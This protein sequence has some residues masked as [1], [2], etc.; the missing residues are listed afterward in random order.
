MFE[1]LHTIMGKQSNGES[2][3]KSGKTKQK[4]DEIQRKKQ[5][6]SKIQT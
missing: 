5:L 6:I 1:K 2:N 4:V 3:L